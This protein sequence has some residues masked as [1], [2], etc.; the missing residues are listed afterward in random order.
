MNLLWL[1]FD[2]GIDEKGNNKTFKGI[3]PDE[4]GYRFDNRFNVSFDKANKIIYIEDNHKYVKLYNE[5][6][7]NFSCI[8]GKNGSGK[9][10]FFELIVTNISWGMNKNQPNFLISLYYEFINDQPEFFIQLY[11][12]NAKEFGLRI[13][14]NKKEINYKMKN[15]DS[16]YKSNMIPGNTKYI[17]HSLSPFDK[18][19]YSIA[20]P[21]KENEKRI[22]HF[23]SQM[24]YI[25]VQ[26]MFSDDFPYEI[27]VISNFIL[28]FKEEYFKKSFLQALRLQFSHIN[29]EINDNYID[30]I[31]KNNNDFF[32][33]IDDM[34]EKLNND[35]RV[36]KYEN[37]NEFVSL[38]DIKS[39]KEFF[40]FFFDYFYE[41]YND[42]E[43]LK[44]LFILNNINFN[45]FVNNYFMQNIDN[46][47]K[48]LNF[49]SC[50][51][52]N[53]ID[54][55]CL[56]KKF[57]SIKYENRAFV[58][59][60]I[61]KWYEELKQVNI[62]EFIKKNILEIDRYEVENFLKIV[63]YLK[64]KELIEF[65]IFLKKDNDFVNYFYLSSGEKTLIS[66]FANIVNSI[67]KFKPLES[68]TFIMLIDEVE[69]HLHPEWQRRFIS[70]MNNF[71]RKNE[72]NMKFQFIIATHSPFIL[73]DIVDEQIIYIREKS[74]LEINT[75]GAN[76]Y[77]IFEKGFF[78]ENSI[79]KYSE[80]M[81]KAIDLILSFYHGLKLAKKGNIFVL[82]KLLGIWYSSKNG[83]ITDTIQRQ[84][85]EKFLK[86]IE[87]YPRKCLKK[88]FLKNNLDFNNYE[89]LFFKDEK[90]S[91][92]IENYIK[93]IGDEVIR[94]HLLNLYES[95]KNESK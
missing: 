30:F 64:S 81:I 92:K 34:L 41:I 59:K 42:N 17:F 48:L 79:G 33:D 87:K 15:N 84:Q 94:N 35:N 16:R 18:I 2:N 6:I 90:L 76:I 85:D 29:V 80:E 25:G 70:Y 21:L 95:L 27:K 19:F 66:Y 54:Y 69:L 55:E 28:M 93:I 63:K 49:Q 10:T 24:D 8:V 12:N 31:K 40:S 47:L 89:N 68:K 1:Y 83:Q 71:F 53:N 57:L 3:M 73:S 14:Y 52:E 74:D 32:E 38:L 86:I 82:R 78:L 39:Q 50:I 77:D 56:S 75:F 7:T 65:E 22:K 26:K 37:L 51:K 9:T 44:W 11:R 36:Q 72:L 20:L 61:G 91:S 23:K 88:L 4:N 67:Y 45:K 62:F 43:K 13:F 58:N 60:D 46:F 5:A